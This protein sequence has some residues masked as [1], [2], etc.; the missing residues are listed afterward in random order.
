VRW[1][2]HLLPVNVNDDRLPNGPIIANWRPESARVSEANPGADQN[3]VGSIELATFLG[4]ITRLD[5][6]LEGETEP[7]MVDLP[8]ADAHEFVPGGIV[9]LNVPPEAI[10]LY[11]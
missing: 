10:R 4:P 8:S 5:V 11:Q 2:R 6:R 9:G 3:L 1:S 7:V